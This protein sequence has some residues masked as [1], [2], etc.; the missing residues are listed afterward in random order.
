MIERLR[1]RLTSYWNNIVSPLGSLFR[2]HRETF[3]G[4][5]HKSINHKKIYLSETLMGHLKSKVS[6]QTMREI[7]LGEY[8]N[9]ERSNLQILL[10][11]DHD[12]Q[13]K[14]IS[15]VSSYKSEKV[16]NI[17]I[18]ECDFPSIF[19]SI[20]KRTI[21]RLKYDQNATL[22]IARFALRSILWFRDWLKYRK[23]REGV[24]HVSS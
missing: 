16:S 21:L 12:K 1:D 4:E 10:I 22:T 20:N 14:L 13:L 9:L 3:L 6:L 19:L 5:I 15:N 2:H 7:L 24:T 17:S 18:E 8:I 23:T 11:W